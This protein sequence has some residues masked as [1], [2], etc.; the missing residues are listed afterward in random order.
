ML[1]VFSRS[2]HGFKSGIRLGNGT[3]IIDSGYRDSVKVKLHND[4]KEPFTVRDGDRIAQ[5]LIQPVPL[6]TF[7][8]VDELA[9]SERG[10]GGLGSTG[11]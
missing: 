7:E 6:V 5:A 11:S 3:G 4:G 1:K 8:V 9:E 2:G 10:L